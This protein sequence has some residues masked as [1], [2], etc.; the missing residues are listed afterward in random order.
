MQLL[1]LLGAGRAGRAHQKVLALLGQREHRDLS[2]ILFARQQHHHALQTHRQAAVR[3]G[4]VAE[5]VQHAAE[6]GFG[7]LA[8]I[9]GDLE[10][11]QHHFRIAVADCAGQHLIAIADDIVLEDL[12]TQ[13]F[14]LVAGTEGQEFLAVILRHRE[15]I[16]GEV[17]LL[18]LLAPFI[19]GIIHHPAEAETAL[20]DQVQ[21]AADAGA[22]ETG[23][24]RGALL[25]V[26]GEEQGIAGFD[27]RQLRHLGDRR[28]RNEFGDR[29]FADQGA[30]LVLE[31]NITQ[32][33]RAFGARPLIELV[34]EAARLAGGARR[35]NAAHRLVLEGLEFDLGA[36]E[37]GAEIGNQDRVA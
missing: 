4:P 9:A 25:L 18:L 12:E 36:R 15:G 16:V 14:V 8:G 20:L 27:I 29:S 17:D 32:A 19:H 6:A 21:F 13:D 33:R 10:G 22:S 1:E 30:G 37:H 3:R 2:D 11:L 23:Q 35:G 5:C 26:G 28:R 24:G 7:F 34:E 31:N